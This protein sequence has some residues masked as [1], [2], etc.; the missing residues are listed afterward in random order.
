MIFSPGVMLLTWKW[1]LEEIKKNYKTITT[2]HLQCLGRDD[3]LYGM[4]HCHCTTR[5]K[6]EFIWGV[7]S[8]E[9]L[10]SQRWHLANLLAVQQQWNQGVTLVTASRH[11]QS[12]KQRLRVSF[13]HKA[14]FQLLPTHVSDPVSLWPSLQPSASSQ[15]F[16]S[17]ISLYS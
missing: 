8:G 17:H 4:I 13:C 14:G 1:H 6:K 9:G 2:L 16:K 7:S 15:S 10:I 3:N 11:I 5:E 12:T